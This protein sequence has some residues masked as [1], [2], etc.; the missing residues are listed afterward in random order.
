MYCP[1]CGCEYQE[2]FYICS[3][4]NIDLVL[5]K[6]IIVENSIYGN[7]SKR[8]GALLIDMVIVIIIVAPFLYAFII[9]MV[10]R[11]ELLNPSMI[12]IF[13]SLIELIPFWLY[14]S[15]FES[16]KFK[17]SVGK[18]I[19]KIIVVDYKGDRLSFKKA[20]IRSFSKIISFML[21]LIGLI[22]VATS[23]KKQAVHDNIAK[24][25]V[26]K[27]GCENEL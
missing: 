9:W 2:G 20:T 23:N 11:D 12:T 24:T 13:S 16:S 10:N 14:F 27:A 4:C 15:L 17:G 6:S 22:I 5:E 21:S 25:I 7:L 19:F 26:L 8:L 3:D 18:M 1:K